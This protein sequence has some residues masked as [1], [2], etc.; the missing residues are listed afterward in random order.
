MYPGS[1]SATY[2][3]ILMETFE[4]L[5]TFRGLFGWLVE[6]VEENLRFFLGDLC[7]FLD[8]RIIANLL[9]GFGDYYESHF[10]AFV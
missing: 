9:L 3:W 10:W 8:F 5:W 6:I 1:E 2:V 7:A 4:G